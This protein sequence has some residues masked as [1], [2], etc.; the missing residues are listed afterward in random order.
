MPAG[1]PHECWLGGLGNFIV[2]R[3]RKVFSKNFSKTV[4]DENRY[5]INVLPLANGSTSSTGGK[6]GE[7][8]GRMH[9]LDA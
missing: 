3:K 7:V 9:R 4:D 1:K 8:L 5:G 2:R 6:R